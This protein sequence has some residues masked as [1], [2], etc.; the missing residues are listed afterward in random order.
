MLA[1]AA[2]VFIAL[3]AGSAHA[4]PPVSLT[5]DAPSGQLVAVCQAVVE[6]ECKGGACACTVG[7]R[8][9]LS[10]LDVAFLEVAGPHLLDERAS[11]LY[12]AVR[13]AAGW[14]WAKVSDRVTPPNA[15][16][17]RSDYRVDD[18]PTLVPA[19]IPVVSFTVT[20]LYVTHAAA[21]NT[22]RT[23]ELR[24]RYYC[25]A[26]AKEDA[27]CASI[28]VSEHEEL[29]AI[30]A[31]KP[32]SAYYGKP[33]VSRHWVRAITQDGDRLTAS[34]REGEPPNPNPSDSRPLE[35]VLTKDFGRGFA[36]TRMRPLAQ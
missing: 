4:A 6:R 8:T 22:L 25:S 1:R 10:G 26:N 29:A 13:A 15:S 33:G 16:E 24:V 18:G 35:Y 32:L 19:S 9:S 17:L 31:S 11:R 34:A 21:D 23:G 36:A 2:F 30:D 7:Q 14:S 12:V 20:S 28:G 5:K 3:V 27:R